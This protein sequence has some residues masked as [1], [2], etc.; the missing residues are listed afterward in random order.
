MPPIVI[1]AVVNHFE[2]EQ[3]TNAKL[4]ATVGPCSIRL[5]RYFD[6]RTLRIRW[7]LAIRL[8]LADGAMRRRVTVQRDGPA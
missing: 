4:H 3:A 2:A 8:H 5:F 1:V 7:Q 6:D